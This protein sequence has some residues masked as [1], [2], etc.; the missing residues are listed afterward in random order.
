[1]SK[2]FDR[3]TR[4]KVGKVPFEVT[5]LRGA[6]DQIVTLASAAKPTAVRLSNAYCVALASKDPSYEALL[7]SDGLN[8]PDGTP[9]VW[10]M[11]AKAEDSRPDRVRGPS[12]FKDTLSETQDMNIGHFFL[13]TSDETLN[14]LMSRLKDDLPNLKVSGHYAPPYA[15]LSAE[16]IEI[17]VR[18]VR[19]TDA[20]IVWVALGTPK[21]D[22]LAAEL[23][24]DTGLVCVAVGAAFDF[25]AGTTKEA[26]IWIQNSGFEWL[27][28]L[29]SEPKR[30]WRRYLFSNIVFIYSAIKEYRL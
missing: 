17:C 5:T 9:V 3:P 19:N 27:Y 30:L 2:V 7:N 24:T 18:E 25:A 15:P 22:F 6:V 10:F 16:S 11:R 14:K 12:L 13:G 8:F 28:R 29:I 26:P 20:Q 4:I 1:M 21:Q 23:A